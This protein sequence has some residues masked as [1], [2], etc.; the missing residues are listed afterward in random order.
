MIYNLTRHEVVLYDQASNPRLSLEAPSETKQLARVK[1]SINIETMITLPNGLEVPIYL[2]KY[3]KPTLDNIVPPPIPGTYYIVPR[4]VADMLRD[5]QD[6]VYPYDLVRSPTGS[7]E[8]CKALAR[9]DHTCKP[10]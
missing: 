10:C 7:V 4:L 2:I 3:T 1:E 6:L 9:F 5:R 8:G